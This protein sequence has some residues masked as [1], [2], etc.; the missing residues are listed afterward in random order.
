MAHRSH[1]ALALFSVLAASCLLPGCS[2][3]GR[4]AYPAPGSME[5]LSVT[6][7]SVRRSENLLSNPMF[8]QWW[9]GAPGPE[10][11]T[12][13]RD[14]VYVMSRVPYEGGGGAFKARQRWTKPEEANPN[15]YFGV[16][17]EGLELGQPYRFEVMATSRGGGFVKIGVWERVAKG[18]PV[19]LNTDLIQIVPHAGQTKI[20]AATF[21]PVKE[22]SVFIGAYTQNSG[23]EVEYRYWSLIEGA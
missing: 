5:V 6:P 15:R 21:T 12:I 10:G 20:Y 14:S 9:A 17:V 4:D 13:A 1:H 23:T 2:G 19:P 16:L 18:L 8:D 11:Y 7:A 22:S 3:E